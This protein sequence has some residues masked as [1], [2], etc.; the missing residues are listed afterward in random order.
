MIDWIAICMNVG[1]LLA[2]VGTLPQIVAVRKD[3]NV[4]RGYDPRGTIPLTMAMLLFAVGFYKMGLWFS[5]ICE[6][7]PIIYWGLASIYSIKGKRN[8]EK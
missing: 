6:I 2:A 8:E 1:T 3:R 4:L 7:P 5:V